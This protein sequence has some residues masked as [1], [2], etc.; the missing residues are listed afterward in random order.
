MYYKIFNRLASIPFD[1]YA[2]L[3][4]VTTTR[5]SHNSKLMPISSKKNPLKFSFMVRTFLI[6]NKLPKEFI[7]C[8]SLD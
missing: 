1:Q 3:S 6:W 2:Q 8:N 7:N 4:L 5:Q